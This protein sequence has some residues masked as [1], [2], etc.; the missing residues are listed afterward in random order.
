MVLSGIATLET[1][2]LQFSRTLFSMSR[3]RAMPT[4]MAHIDARTQTPVRTTVLL[5]L[6]GLAMI[7]ASSFIRHCRPDHHGLGG[8]GGAYRS[9]ITDG[10]AG[11]VCAWVY[12]RALTE[13]V[14]Q[15]DVLYAIT[16]TRSWSAVALIALGIYA[17]TTFNTITRA[18]WGL[19]AC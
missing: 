1:S 16:A 17:C 5:I 13:S 14:A 6:L 9:A 4:A 15:P 3:E 11:L 18:W 10:I 8:R 2:M 12:R 7:F 19:A